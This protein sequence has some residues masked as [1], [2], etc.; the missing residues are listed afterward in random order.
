LLLIAYRSAQQVSVVRRWLLGTT[1]VAQAL[2]WALMFH[3]TCFGWLIFRARSWRQLRDMTGGLFFEFAPSTA[4]LHGIVVPLVLFTTPLL[5]VHAC[6]AY[7]NDVLVVR[8]LPIGV[9]Y[10][11]YAATFYLTMLFGNFGGSDFI[12]FQF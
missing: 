11:V 1:P 5:L 10:S 8:R 7:F 12:Y 2:G 9:R 3:F 4:D 6:E